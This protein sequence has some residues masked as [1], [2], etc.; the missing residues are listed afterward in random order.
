LAS[1][2]AWLWD[3]GF[4]GGGPQLELLRRLAHWMM[5]EPELEENA[6]VADAEGQ[7][8][9]LT[10]RALSDEAHEVSVVGPDGAV[11]LLQ[12]DSVGPGR[13]QTTFEAPEPGLYRL[14]EGDL[15]TVIGIGPAAP[16]EFINTM[17]S[18]D[19][20]GALVA[21]AR[22]GILPIHAGVPDIRL[23]RQNRVASGR[24]WIGLT[25]RHAAL[26]SDLQV[27]P[28][29]AAWIFLPLA[30]LLSLAAWL[31]ESRHKLAKSLMRKT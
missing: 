2:H 11:V 28:L 8:M 7:T 13:A 29:V 26:T 22:G 6:L 3:R 9:T 4:E 31:R 20:L 19:S 18:A 25:P 30:V 27:S 15:E 17:A 16:R 23:V 21:E 14:Q 10:R 5:G 1:D 12:L 24:G